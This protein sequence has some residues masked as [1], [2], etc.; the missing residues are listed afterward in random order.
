MTPEKLRYAAPIAAALVFVAGCGGTGD[1]SDSIAQKIG[2][3]SCTAESYEVISR[4]DN[5]HSRIYDCVVN[6]NELC[7]TEQNG[8]ASNATAEVRLLFSNTLGADVPACLG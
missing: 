5:H 3:S 8:I 7:V 2:A 1:Q 6:G 4:I